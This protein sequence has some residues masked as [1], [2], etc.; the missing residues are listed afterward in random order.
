MLTAM[1]PLTPDVVLPVLTVM[2]P[3]SPLEPE[4]AVAIVMEPESSAV[5]TPLVT[6][7]AP[8]VLAPR[9]PGW[10]RRHPLTRCCP[11]RCQPSASARLLRRCQRWSCLRSRSPPR[12]GR[13][14]HPP[15]SG[16]SHPRAAS[17]DA[18]LHRKA[19][20]A[21]KVEVPVVSVMLPLT[22]LEPES[23]VA[24]VMEPDVRV[25][26]PLSHSRRRPSSPE[27]TLDG[28]GPPSDPLLP[29]PMPAFSVSAPPAA[30]SAVVLPS[31]STVP[32]CCHPPRS[33]RS[34]PPRRQLRCSA[35]SKRPR[36]PK[37]RGPGCPLPLTPL[38]PSRRSRSSW[39]LSRPQFRRRSS[40]SRR[41]PC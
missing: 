15:R 5:P 3:L 4:L 19:P 35:S 17:C 12:R 36:R 21:P 38:E 41:R 24:I 37:S 16:R 25:P 40:H 13:C 32:S 6:L 33:G 18:R 27:A 31:R 23:A 14:C 1:P 9:P 28:H 20:V 7:T 39:S 22:P 30:L 2:L 11:H 26:T 34:H 8:P 29:S 10:T